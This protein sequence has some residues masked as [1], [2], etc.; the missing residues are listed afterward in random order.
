MF[1]ELWTHR[2]T[3]E[4]AR[5]AGLKEQIASF[6]RE[7][8]KL[9]SRIIETETPAVVKAME[10]RVMPEITKMDKALAKQ[11]ENEMFKFEHLFALSPQAMGS[12]LR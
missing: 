4:Q 9:V 7:I 2:Q 11:I 3:T 6:E 5:T 8:D 12:L 1:E 10:K